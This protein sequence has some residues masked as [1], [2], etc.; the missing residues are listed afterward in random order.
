MDIEAD[1]LACA[2]RRLVRVDDV[3]R[4]RRQR[5]Q[6]PDLRG[7]QQ[8]DL[9]RH[10]RDP[11][12]ERGRVRLDHPLR[13]RRQRRQRPGLQRHQ[14]ALLGHRRD[15]RAHRCRVWRLVVVRHHRHHRARGV[16]LQRIDLAV[17][18]RGRL[19]RPARGGLPC[20]LVMCGLRRSRQLGVG[21]RVDMDLA[22]LDRRHPF[23][24]QCHM[25]ADDGDVRRR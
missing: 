9:V 24:Y 8:L 23:L 1:R 22:S 21:L 14:L 19:L 7:R 3:L 11:S 2:A 17:D 16:Q 6:R 18:H 10:R 15:D 12:I 13:G 25:P 4:C 5:R 20:R